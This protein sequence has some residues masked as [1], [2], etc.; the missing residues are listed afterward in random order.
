MHQRDLELKNETK[1]VYWLKLL[2]EWRKKKGTKIAVLNLV[3]TFDTKAY[4]L[5]LDFIQNLCPHDTIS[6]VKTL[7]PQLHTKKLASIP[8]TDP[9]PAKALL[10]FYASDIN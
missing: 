9:N 8:S 4:V 1:C 5:C 7:Q 3:L 6:G 10:P 2:F